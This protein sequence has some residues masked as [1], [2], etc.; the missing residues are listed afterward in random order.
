MLSSNDLEWLKSV[1]RNV[2]NFPKEGVE[3][4]DITTVLENPKANKLVFEA[5][6]KKAEELRIDRIV[7]IDSRGFIFGNALALDLG[8][9]FSLVRKKG[10]L[11]SET[12]EQSYS[13]EYGEAIVEIHCDSIQSGERVL[14]HDDLLATGGTA[15]AAAQLV[16]K[17]GGEVAAFQFIIELEFL[18]GAQSLKQFSNNIHTLIAYS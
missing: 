12:I 6:R 17:L 2:P 9:P 11:P 16:E 18:N 7:G 1:V 5:F 3:F 8:V 13:L 10:K 14:I 4:K 15:Q